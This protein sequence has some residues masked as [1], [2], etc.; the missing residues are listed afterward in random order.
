MDEAS[1]SGARRAARKVG[2]VAR[3]SRCRQDMDNRGEFQD[4]RPGPQLDRS[5]REVRP[6]P[7]RRGAFLPRAGRHLT[8]R[9][10]AFTGPPHCREWSARPAA[11]RRALLGHARTRPRR[12]SDLARSLAKT[13]CAPGQRN[14]PGRTTAHDLGGSHQPQDDP[15]RERGDSARRG[16]A[17]RRSRGRKADQGE[18][19]YA[20]HDDASCRVDPR[21]SRVGERTQPSL[22]K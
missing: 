2:L 18:Q 5:G 7:R 20:T 12:G 21:E 3:K 14:N 11:R 16:T 4:S 10:R 22:R 17:R 6:Q 9:G 8:T 19:R 1:E 13:A 15:K